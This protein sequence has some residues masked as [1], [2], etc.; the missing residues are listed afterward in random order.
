[1][2]R[3]M[4]WNVGGPRFNSRIGN[5]LEI[6]CDFGL[7]ISLIFGLKNNRWCENLENIKKII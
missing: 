6:C 1:V 3:A 5:F 7:G 2:I 4:H